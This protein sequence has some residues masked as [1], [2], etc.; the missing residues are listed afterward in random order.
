MFT[1]TLI[2]VSPRQL[3]QEHEIWNLRAFSW[4]RTAKSTIYG[5]NVSFFCLPG[6]P[7]P[8]PPIGFNRT[9]RG[10]KWEVQKSMGNWGPHGNIDRLADCIDFPLKE[11]EFFFRLKF[12]F[13][14]PPKHRWNTFVKDSYSLS[15]S[16]WLVLWKV[17]T[18]SCSCCSLTKR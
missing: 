2:C 13:F 5:K 7:N 1:L 9:H 14:H 10:T 17:C 6:N 3:V 16:G 12:H 11:I 4:W 15:K 18:Y 8:F